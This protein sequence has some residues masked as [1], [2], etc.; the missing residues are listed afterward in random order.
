MRVNCKDVMRK[1]MQF[2]ML[3]LAMTAVLPVCS[4]NAELTN[5]DVP[6]SDLP[7]VSGESSYVLVPGDQI[8]VTV[9]FAAEINGKLF[10]IDSAGEIN[11][12]FVGSV[13][14]AGSTVPALEAELRPLFS[15][16]FTTP[17]ITVTLSQAVGQTVSI[18]GAVRNPTVV[19]LKG[20][21][22]LL[23]ILAAGGGVSPEAGPTLTIAREIRWG[24]LPLPGSH[25]DTAGTATIADVN[26]SKLLAGDP[27][28][29]IPVLPK[30]AITVKKA[31]MIFVWGDVKKP[32]AFPMTDHSVV[33]AVQALSLADGLLNTASPQ[34]ALILRPHPGKRLEELPV[35]LKKVIER[36]SPDIILE[37]DDVLY[38]P[39]SKAKTAMMRGVEAAIQ[40][41]TG[42]VVWR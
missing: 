10:Q 8:S 23:E 33:S 11:L 6:G 15:P 34:G 37:A 19:E 30:D 22:T 29:D 41:G 21:K 28:E 14:A 18:S 25:P 27:A 20:R 4:L 9:M 36:K 42:V 24:P 7:V 26:V 32:G 17:R 35:N 31:R 40:M 39:N 1:D 38:I 13:H 16:Y 5:A 2:V 12:P 3:M